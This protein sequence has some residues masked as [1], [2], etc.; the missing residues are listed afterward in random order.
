[1]YRY[2]P[3]TLR[4]NRLG[5]SRTLVEERWDFEVSLRLYTYMWSVTRGMKINTKLHFNKNRGPSS[6]LSVTALLFLVRHLPDAKQYSAFRNWYGLLGFSMIMWTSTI[7]NHE[8]EA[9]LYRI[10][11]S[12]RIFEAHYKGKYP[13]KLSFIISL[14]CHSQIPAFS[15]I[16]PQIK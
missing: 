5:P 12:L 6:S 14:L 3:K 2:P 7:N 13:S 4:E 15:S 10:S 9:L 16:T 8:E 11:R 1:M